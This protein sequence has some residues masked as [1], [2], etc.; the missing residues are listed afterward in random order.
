M[1]FLA[2]FFRSR[3]SRQKIPLASGQLDNGN[4]IIYNN[5]SLIALKRGTRKD[6]QNSLFLFIIKLITENTNVS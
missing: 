6:L 4:L 1:P 5:S 2:P 3:R